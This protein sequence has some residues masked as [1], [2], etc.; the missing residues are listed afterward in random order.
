VT[1]VSDGRQKRAEPVFGAA[2]QAVSQASRQPE[3]TPPFPPTRHKVR[4]E[5][6]KRAHRKFEFLLG[7]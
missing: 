5:R 7:A 3:E 2:L 4:R 1:G 6:E